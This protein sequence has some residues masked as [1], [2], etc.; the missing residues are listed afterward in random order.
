MPQQQVAKGH[1]GPPGTCP[2][3]TWADGAIQGNSAQLQEAGTSPNVPWLMQGHTQGKVLGKTACSETN[4]CLWLGVAEEGRI[5][6]SKDASSDFSEVG[7][8][9]RHANLQ[10]ASSQH[11]SLPARRY[12]QEHSSWEAS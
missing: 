8:S 6:L 5:T 10:A 3:N 11:T 12:H 4:G 7:L 2:G 1:K 9:P